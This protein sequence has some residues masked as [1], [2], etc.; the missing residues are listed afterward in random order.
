VSLV[1]VCR[2]SSALVVVFACRHPLVA[3]PRST[4]ASGR[5]WA[6]SFCCGLRAYRRGPRVLSSH[7]LALSSLCSCV[8]LA[9]LSLS[10]MVSEAG[11]EERGTGG[12]H[13]GVLTTT[14]DERWSS[15]VVW[16]QM[17]VMVVVVTV[18]VALPRCR[19]LCRW[20]LFSRWALVTWRC[21]LV[22]VVV[23]V[24]R[25]GGWSPTVAGG[26]GSGH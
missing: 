14:N 24:C 15:F 16:L 20:W 6:M 3:C 25:R 4:L 21:H 5:R 26:D 11:W 22:V 8:L 10:Y 1:A 13:R 19:W 18:D 9:A 7:F 12:T 17:S 23:G 2:W